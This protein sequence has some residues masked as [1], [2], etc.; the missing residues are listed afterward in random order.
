MGKDVIHALY[1]LNIRIKV[2]AAMLVKNLQ[3]G[4][5][6]YVCKLLHIISLAAERDAMNVIVVLVPF[7][8]FVV[9]KKLFPTI[10]ISLIFGRYR[11]SSKPAVMDNFRYRFYH[12][13]CSFDNT[14]LAF[15][16][17]CLY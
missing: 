9:R 17:C 11:I 3:P 6:T 10:D 5:V 15:Q 12:E 2:N 16:Y 14:V 13:Y 4:I 1:H 8:D 7:S